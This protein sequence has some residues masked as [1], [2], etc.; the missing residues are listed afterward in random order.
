MNQWLD[1]Y[2]ELAKR[3][4]LYSRAVAQDRVSISKLILLSKEASI[5]MKQV[6]RKGLKH[7]VVAEAPEPMVIS[8]SRAR[9]SSVFTYQQRHG[10]RQHS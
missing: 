1:L 10:E 9:E 8:E 6:F 4:K 3:T 7:I 5:P 2:R